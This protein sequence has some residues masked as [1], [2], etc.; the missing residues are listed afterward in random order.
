MDRKM[1]VVEPVSI[2]VF[3]LERM[4]GNLHSSVSERS[5]SHARYPVFVAATTSAEHDR[6]QDGPASISDRCPVEFSQRS[7]RKPGSFTARRTPPRGCACLPG[8]CHFYP[9]Y[10]S[11]MEIF[12]RPISVSCHLLAS[13]SAVDGELSPGRGMETFTVDS[14]PAKPVEV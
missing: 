6:V 4:A 7:F 11:A 5:Y 9:A 10:W 1:F 2:P 12:T 13:A 14:G 8:R 3:T